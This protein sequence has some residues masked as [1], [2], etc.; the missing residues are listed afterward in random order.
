MY[1]QN[2]NKPFLC[3]YKKTDDERGYLRKP[4]IPDFIKD[5]ELL[6][7]S[8]VYVSESKKNIF[9]GLHYQIEPHQQRK[10]FIVLK[11]IVTFYCYDLIDHDILQFTL[12]ENSANALFSPPTWAI[13]YHTK[14][15]INQVFFSSPEAY[16]P[17]SERVISCTVIKGLDV[18]VLKRS[19][20]DLV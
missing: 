4:I 10:Y 6:K 14:A 2:F 19:K 3:Q 11:G 18:S 9:R 1:T 8:D 5:V 20:K 12:D 13:G 7:F 17:D 16:V 15:D